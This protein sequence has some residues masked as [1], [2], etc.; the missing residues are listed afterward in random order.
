MIKWLKRRSLVFTSSVI[1][2]VLIFVIVTILHIINNA[3]Q[4]QNVYDSF[5]QIGSKLKGQAQANVQLIEPIIRSV[6]AEE[7]LP[8]SEMEITSRLLNAIIDDDE[9]VT[10]A[11]YYSAEEAQQDGVAAL[12]YLQVSNTLI[13]NG[14]TPGSTYVPSETVRAE[15]Q[16]AVK[17]EELLTKTYEDDYGKWVSYFGPIRDANGKVIAVFGLDFDYDRVDRLTS[18]IQLKNSVI[19]LIVEVIS[20]TILVFLLRFALRPLRR[21]ADRAREAAQGDLTVSLPVTNENEI[22]QASKAFNEMISS[23]RELTIQIDRTS[24]EVAESSNQLKETAEQTEA[25]TNDIAKSI[26]EV[27]TGAETQLVSSQESQRAMTEMAVGISRIAESSSLV[28][29]LAVETSSLATDGEGVI[30]QTVSQMSIIEERVVGATQ[31]MEQLNSASNR[32]GEI[33]SHISEVADQTNLL[34]LNASIEAAR[35]GEQGKGFAVVAQEI[36]K[37]AERSQASSNEISEILHEIGNR[38]QEVANSLHK[39]TNETK[40][41]AELVN[42][43]GN[44]FRSI[45]RSVN[46]VSAQVQEVSAASEQMSAGSEQIAASLVELENMSHTSASHS[47]QVAA[48]SEEQLASM[49]EVASSAQQL[50][51]LADDLRAAVGRFKV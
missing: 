25:A 34:A 42:A 33:L 17:G 7:A 27:A 6:V 23:L 8:A 20:I 3:T 13:N 30:N 45:L 35:A 47:Q 2:A 40:I 4:Q 19:A 29:E 50:K 46:V 28:S 18:Q 49:E 37:L 38:S 1:I 32:I 26:Q 15:F 48:S 24:R 22:G 12:Q 14:F 43:S 5:E 16:L 39:T 11:Y 41:G 21:L 9:F 44:S 31:S 51:Q 36:R 10:N